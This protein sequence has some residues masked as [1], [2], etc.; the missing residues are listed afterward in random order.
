MNPALPDIMIS[1]FANYENNT[2]MDIT[3]L[4]RKGSAG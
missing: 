3:T 1:N 2:S 4:L